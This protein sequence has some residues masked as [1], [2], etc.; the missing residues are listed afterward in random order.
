MPSLSTLDTELSAVNTI[1]GSIG[2]APISS[3]NDNTFTNPEVDFIYKLLREANIDIQSE[4]WSFNKENHILMSI[5]ENGKIPVANNILHIDFSSE[6]SNRYTDAVIRNSF[7]YDKVNHTDIYTTDKYCD[8]VYLLDFTDI[9]QVFR[10]YISYAASSKAATQLVANPQLVQ[11]L[12]TKEA[13]ARSICMEHECNQGDYSYLGL[14][15]ET[16]YQS[17]QPFHAL[18][19]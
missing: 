7:I 3:L 9:P 8:V 13:H 12:A 19:R 5:D 4:G 18:R 14:G 17:Y 1:L 2:Q 11:L 16:N 10:R 6:D 15:H